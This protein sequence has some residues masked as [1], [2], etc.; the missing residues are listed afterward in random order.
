MSSLTPVMRENASARMQPLA[1][2]DDTCVVFNGG[3]KP[4]YAL[5]H[6][7]LAL[8]PRQLTFV[9]GSSGCG[10]TTLLNVLGGMI[11]PDSGTVLFRGNDISHLSQRQKTRYRR[12]SVGFIF[13]RYNLIASLTARENVMV[14]ASLTPGSMNPLEALDLVGLRHK[15]DA[16][17]HQMSGGEQ[18]RV[19]IARAICKNAGLILADEPTGA[20]DVENARNVMTV[21][22]RLV[23]ENGQTVLVVTHNPDLA[24]MA[25]RV[26]TMRDGRIVKDETNPNPLS[27]RECLG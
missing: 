24:P 15:A 27:A 11:T 23:H 2:V 22:E 19:C 14:S 4:F 10:K 8:Y 17:P 3:E 18:Q 9:F 6:L 16:Y 5:N 1:E 21:L 12:D 20:L 26:I 25:D 7:T 13:Q